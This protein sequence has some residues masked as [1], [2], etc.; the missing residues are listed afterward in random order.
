MSEGRSHFTPHVRAGNIQNLHIS[1]HFT[2]NS[3]S[4]MQGVIYKL[5]KVLECGFSRDK[6]QNHENKWNQR[7]KDGTR[8]F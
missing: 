2:C 7:G 3:I 5:W 4:N 1:Y 8:N 6:S